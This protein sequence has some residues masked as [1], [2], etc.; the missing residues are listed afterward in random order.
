MGTVLSCDG[1]PMPT[2]RRVTRSRPALLALVLFAGTACSRARSPHKPFGVLPS[3]ST[4]AVP[5]WLPERAVGGAAVDEDRRETHLFAPRRL[6]TGWDVTQT[7]WSADGRT[8]FAFASSTA[9]RGPALFAVDASGRAAPKALSAEGE[10]VLSFAVRAGEGPTRV[11]Y[12]ARRDATS[13]TVLFEVREGGA[14]VALD[15]R[16]PAPL[17][18]APGPGGDLLVVTKDGDRARLVRLPERGDRAGLG[19]DEVALVS[20]ALSPDRAYVVFARRSEDPARAEAVDFASVEGRG[21]TEL[22]SARGASFRGLSFHPSGRFV[23]FAADRD[24]AAFELYAVELPE[25]LAGAARVSTRG[26]RDRIEARTVRLTFSQGDAPAFSPDGK[27]LSFASSRLGP[28]RDLY[29]ARFI[30]AP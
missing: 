3:A 16:G 7:G 13:E 24:R 9:G 30:E 22:V 12:A 1:L 17:A 14:P 6:T 27:S 10:R 19:V 20:P 18:L 26:E 2:F 4:K 5:E 8:I 25:T 29:V 15:A 23:A 21:A 28:T 11:V